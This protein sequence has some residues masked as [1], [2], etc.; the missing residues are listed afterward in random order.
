VLG[1]LL[2]FFARP[3]AK[4]GVAAL[5]AAQTYW[6][7]APSSDDAHGFVQRAWADRVAQ[8]IAIE[9][10]DRAGMSSLAVLPLVNDTDRFV[11]QRVHDAI[12]RRGRYEVIQE[13]LRQRIL[14]EVRGGDLSPRTLEDAV[15]MAR[16]LGSDL[17]LFGEFTTE[18]VGTIDSQVHLNVRMAERDSGHAVFTA[19]YESG[20][21]P[22]A[23]SATYWRALVADSPKIQRGFIWLVAVFLLPIVGVRVIRRVTAEESNTWNAALI[24]SYAALSAALAYALT[25]FWIASS[26]TVPVIVAAGVAGGYYI[27]RFASLVDDLRR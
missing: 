13:S 6:L 2:G 20:A 4:V 8:Q 5:F 18:P 7:L 3:V 11:T 22:G 17:V 25:G 14:R 15:A 19:R 16:R 10:P 24:A 9:L 23:T 27:F 26:W 1:F 12:G 21:E